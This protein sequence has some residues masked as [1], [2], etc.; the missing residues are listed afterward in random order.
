MEICAARGAMLT[1]QET[2]DL[3]TRAYRS[4]RRQTPGQRTRVS[5][6]G[7]ALDGVQIAVTDEE[8]RNRYLDFCVPTASGVVQS[9]YVRENGQTWRFDGFERG[10][11]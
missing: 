10:N 3:R 1:T 11:R 5:F 2:A 9:L 8:A 4:Q 6:A 7:G